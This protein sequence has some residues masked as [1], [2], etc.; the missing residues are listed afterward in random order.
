MA[1]A[2]VK[3]VKHA[4]RV[5]QDLS[6]VWSLEVYPE[7]A[8]K[9]EKRSEPYKNWPV[10]LVLKI[11]ADSRAHALVAGLAQMKSLGKIDGFEVDEAE[12]PPPPPAS[13]APA[14]KEGG[15]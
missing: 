2:T 6:D 5:V 11:R 8:P 3:G 15:A 4:V 7:P 9:K 12:K 13:P 14:K 1:Y 10:P